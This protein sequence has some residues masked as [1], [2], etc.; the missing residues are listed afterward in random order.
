MT[1]IDQLRQDRRGRRARHQ[2]PDHRRPRPA[3]RHLPRGQHSR[4]SSARTPRNQATRGD[5]A[6]E[7]P[8]R[9]RRHRA[10]RARASPSGLI[11]SGVDPT[12]PF[13]QE[14]DGTSAVVSNNK[15]LCDPS[16]RP[17]RCVNLPT[18]SVD[19]DTLSAGRPRHPRRRH[20]RRPAD[21]PLRRA[22]ASTAPPRRQARVA[23]H[24]RGA[25]YPRR[26][27]GPQLGAREPRRA[28]R[29]GRPGRRSA[30]RSRSPTTPTA[31]PAAASSTRARRP[32]SCSGRSRP[33]AW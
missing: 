14:A 10:R 22:G 1:T 33:R 13:L 16:S 26:R 9:R 32:S 27:R 7:H 4:S 11:D 24:R 3:G 29:R 23:L 28:L 15:V 2:G 6:I 5:E 31:R 30:R 18:T 17:A 21:H 19:T 12:H 20:H 8:H 25:R